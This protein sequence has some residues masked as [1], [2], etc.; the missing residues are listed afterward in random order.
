MPRLC[1]QCLPAMMALSTHTRFCKS[2]I[3]IPCAPNIATAAAI[4]SAEHLDSAECCCSAAGCLAT[5][6]GALAEGAGTRPSRALSPQRA[7]ASRRPGSAS[8][9]LRARAGNAAFSLYSSLSF[10]CSVCSRAWRN[11]AW[12][13]WAS[14][15]PR[16]PVCHG[17]AA[18][19][20]VAGM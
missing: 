3:A 16:C 17:K 4:L 2:Y 14:T 12:P 5:G 20:A 8:A 7:D 18:A 9:T 1:G 19:A 11:E 13:P 15:A 6:H 10:T